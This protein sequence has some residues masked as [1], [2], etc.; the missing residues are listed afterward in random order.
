MNAFNLLQGLETLSLRMERHVSNALAV[1]RFLE[2]HPKVGRVHYAGLPSH[3]HHDRVQKYL[4]KGA[5]AVFAF[6]ISGSDARQAGKRFIESLQLFSHLA[7]VGDAKS[8]VIHPASTTHQQMS[9]AELEAARITPGFAAADWDP[10]IGITASLTPSPSDS[11]KNR[12]PR[13]AFSARPEHGFRCPGN[14]RIALSALLAQE[15]RA[16]GLSWQ[17]PD[18]AAGAAP[19]GGGPWL[20]A[21]AR[22]A[23]GL[24]S[25]HSWSLYGRDVLVGNF[26]HWTENQLVCKSETC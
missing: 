14:G 25:Q 13:R 12:N 20:A 10:G 16:L 19:E 1:A 7:N 2:A 11:R 6:E 21:L 18:S 23:A 5:G 4:P 8:L 3:P 17:S 24:A 26:S 15:A 9:D 22:A